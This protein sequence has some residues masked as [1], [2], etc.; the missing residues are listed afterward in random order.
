MFQKFLMTS[1]YLG[2]V[3]DLFN[4]IRTI[5]TYLAEK[6]MF[7]DTENYL[8]QTENS[9]KKMND[10]QA[11]A[12]FLSAIL[13][14]LSFILPLGA[15]L[16]FVIKGQAEPAAIIAIFLASDRVVG[17]LRNAAQCL[18]EM[19][20]TENNNS[21]LNSPSI[22]IDDVSFAYNDKK[23]ILT[24]LSLTIP[25]RTKILITGKSGAG[26]STIFNLIEGFIKPTSG[27]IFLQ[28][29]SQVV[30]NIAGSGE[31]AYI[32]QSPFMFNDTLRLNLTL[33]KEFSDEECLKAL[34]AVGL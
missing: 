13:S 23:V 4:G 31:L 33:G 11:W 19:K 10:Y 26:K 20:T 18:N 22:K 7:K 34:K 32:A 6:T 3:T 12:I 29:G 16:F 27:Q 14:A 17:P 2:K 30:K 25:F 9:Y 21:H 15:G 24:N 5:K 1:S 28:D 8:Q